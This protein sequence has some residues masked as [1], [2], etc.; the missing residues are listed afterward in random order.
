MNQEGGRF[1][2]L[3]IGMA[4]DSDEK[5]ESFCRHVSKNFS[6]PFSL[7]RKI[8]E[9]C[10]IVLKKNLSLRSAEKLADTLQSLGALVSIEL[11]REDVAISLDF[12][13]MGPC[14]IALESSSLSRT[15]NGMWN[16]IG[17]VRNVSEDSLNDTWVLIQLFDD[18]EKL[19]TFEQALLP[20]N[21]IP[22]GNASPFR[23]TFEGH[24]PVKKASIAFKNS[25][26][27]PLSAADG[28]RREGA[29]R[30]TASEVEEGLLPSGGILMEEDSQSCGETPSSEEKI[31]AREGEEGNNQNPVR[32]P[33]MAPE[34]ES[35]REGEKGDVQTQLEPPQA[36]TGRDDSLP[37]RESPSDLLED[38]PQGTSLN[39]PEYGHTDQSLDKVTSRDLLSF[40][41][42]EEFR[43]SIEAYSNKLQPIFCSWFEARRKEGAF[44]NSNHF[45]LTIMVHSR[46]DQSSDPLHSL[47]NTEKVFQLILQ[48]NLSLEEIPSLEGTSLQ[49]GSDWRNL[50]HRAIP[51]L[52]QVADKILEQG[53]WNASELERLI[54]IIPHMDSKSS[55]RAVWWITQLI[56]DS[57]EVDYS[58][59]PVIVEGGLYRVASRLGVV[60]PHFDY[61]QGSNSTGDL[62]IQAFAKEAF[63]QC[64]IKIEEPM[65]W[66]GTEQEEGGHCF[67]NQPRCEGCPFDSFCPKL[68]Y[69]F[70]PAE[71]GMRGR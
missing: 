27:N 55:R 50:F 23:L 2:V 28:R 45:L 4:E 67:P 24:L 31:I 65:T 68:Y 6:I 62:K 29:K 36:L 61:Y 46:F 35:N 21:P 12:E 70:N 34:R 30:E 57:V 16:V 22:P 43:N 5:R 63:P 69:D 14:R 49:P 37:E 8:V 41:W 38:L 40:S 39:S 15:A 26:G 42:M 18:F 17:R 11:K 54:Q 59:A 19:L 20:I 53:R 32:P 7:L 47:G 52:Q 33:E 3:L 13:G 64:P 71:K 56:P 10:P 1:Q 48:P 9:R 66:L 44:S 60:D 58:E 25:S 51:K